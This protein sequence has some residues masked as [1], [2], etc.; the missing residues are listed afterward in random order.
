MCLMN[1]HIFP[2]TDELHNDRKK[3]QI[4]SY[5]PKREKR[6][7]E[8]VKMELE[9]IIITSKQPEYKENET[10]Y[11]LLIFVLCTLFCTKYG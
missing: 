5:P 4:L 11:F 2:S 10:L 9:N 6:E 8:R 7:R 3:F 1:M